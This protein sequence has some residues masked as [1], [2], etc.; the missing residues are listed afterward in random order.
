[1]QE[2]RS[3]APARTRM[4]SRT[5]ATRRELSAAFDELEAMEHS[6]F[7]AYS[8]RRLGEGPRPT[9]GELGAQLGVSPEWAR[10][11]VMR[12]EEEIRLRARR[13][14]WPVAAAAAK[15]R[16]ELG[17]LARVEDL[18][19]ARDAVD[20][21]GS[22]LAPA[23]RWALI[24]A[25][26]GPYRIDDGWLVT[27]EADAAT[28]EVLARVSADEPA[29]VDAVSAAMAAYGIPQESAAAWIEH[30]PGF[31]VIDDRVVRWGG[32]LLDKA[33]TILRVVGK[34][35]SADEIF[36]GSPPHC[37]SP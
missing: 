37:A 35:M 31:R 27:D 29:R 1:M 22:A 12:A 33:E 10:Q 4:E 2:S 6:A 21:D 15:V 25:L 9:L 13:P 14:G 28:A 3:G 30:Q 34:P 36:D 11:L 7:R 23:H 20:P 26:A 8:L 24:V 18:E 5:S 16:R 17:I 32:T 19:R